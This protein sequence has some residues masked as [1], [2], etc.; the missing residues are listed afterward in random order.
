MEAETVVVVLSSG[1][2]AETAVVVFVMISLGVEDWV[3][4]QTK[5]DTHS[6]RETV[7]EG[8]I[9]HRFEGQIK[10]VSYDDLKGMILNR[11]LEVPIA[12][13]AIERQLHA[14]ILDRQE[15]RKNQRCGFVNTKSLASSSFLS[16]SVEG[17][18]SGCDGGGVG[19]MKNLVERK[20]EGGGSRFLYLFSPESPIGFCFIYVS[21]DYQI[22]FM[23]FKQLEP[24][25]CL[26]LP[27]PYPNPR[28]VLPLPNPFPNPRIVLPLP[29]P[30]PNPRIVLPLPNP[31]PNPRIVLP[32]PNP[33]PNP[34]IVLP[35]PNPYP[36]PRIVFTD[37]TTMEIVWINRSYYKDIAL[38]RL[39]T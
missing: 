34:R 5:L 25:K 35:L 23:T 24:T 11:D 30:Y 4:R 1:G 3:D 37:P 10:E 22:L 9:Q 32:L 31:Y 28:I 16:R 39:S 20:V 19:A 29:N 12:S 17:R 6:I 14:K 26:P 18:D 33:Y 8:L 27:N 15:S 13:E 2:E 36:N 7:I 38:A 21:G